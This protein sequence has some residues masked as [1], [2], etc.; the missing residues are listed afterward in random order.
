M[1]FTKR[2]K[3]DHFNY[4]I[5]ELV[6]NGKMVLDVGCATGKLL[7]SLKINKNCQVFGM[8][9]NEDMADEANKRCKNIM[10]ADV[11]SC[12]EL[13]FEKGSF[14][15][16][17]FADVLEHL[18][19]PDIALRR[20]IPYLKDNGYFLFS[21]PNVAFLTVRLGLLFGKFVY[22]EYGVLDKTHLRFFTL[23]TARE[24]I[25]EAGLKITH[26][27]GYNQVRLRYFILKPLGKM[28]K[29]IF[30][31]DFVIRAVVHKQS[32]Q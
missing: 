4:R 17:I 27:E 1:F 16:I 7:E 24:L 30:A 10:R 21:I 28:F 19:R 13:P 9:V 3:Y 23:K 15:I 8:E 20:A 2:I 11:E 31:T 22:T 12:E 18:K 25:E 32:D 29:S 5:F 6:E 26:L 14:D